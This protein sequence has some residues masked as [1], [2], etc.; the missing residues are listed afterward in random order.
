MSVLGPT[1]KETQVE[2]SLT[3]ARSIGVQALIRE[4]GDIAGSAP[5]TLEGPCGTIELKEGCIVAKRHV[6]L[7]PASAEEYGV[8]NG[9]VVSVKIESPLGRS[10]TFSDVVIR[11]SE[12]FA[13]AMHV[14][15]DEGNAAGIKGTVFGTIIK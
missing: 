4:S 1:R 11:V 8:K 10:L 3:D 13:P 15:T 14:D 7:D 6:H 12:K 5:I 2:I 9:D